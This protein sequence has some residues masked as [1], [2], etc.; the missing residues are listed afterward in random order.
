MESN[1]FFNLKFFNTYG[2]SY[3]YDTIST[4][5]RLQ[6]DIYFKEALDDSV[7]QDYASQIRQFI[8]SVVEQGNDSDRLKISDVIAYTTATYMDYIDHIDFNG[9][10]GTFNQYIKQVTLTDSERNKYPLEYFNLDTASVS[11]DD[12]TSRIMEDIRFF[13]FNGTEPIVETNN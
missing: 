12:N 4:N 5:V 3:L 13:D 1:T 8:R 7:K 10:N 9:L 11:D 6:L 2:I